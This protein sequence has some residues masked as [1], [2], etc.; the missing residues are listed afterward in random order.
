MGDVVHFDQGNCVAEGTRLA[1]QYQAAE[2]FPHI[3]IDCLLEPQILREA[4]ADFPDI[5]GNNFF[6]VIRNG[7]NSSLPQKK[8]KLS[9]Y[10]IC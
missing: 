8:S 1:V 9:Y 3:V 5:D 6:I 7:L 2:P 4:L 10:A